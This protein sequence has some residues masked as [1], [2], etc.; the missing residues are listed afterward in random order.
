MFPA[1]TY[2][3]LI[4]VPGSCILSSMG[5]QLHIYVEDVGSIPA[6][7]VAT[8]MW[9]AIAFGF[10]F[11]SKYLDHTATGCWSIRPGSIPGTSIIFKKG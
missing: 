1:Q 4:N 8:E 9:Q 3:F 10:S 5:E 2:C 11:I 6:G 7:Y